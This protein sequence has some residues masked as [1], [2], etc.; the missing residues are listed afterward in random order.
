MNC[1]SLLCLSS[2]HHKPFLLGF[3]LNELF[4]LF[5]N[6]ISLDFLRKCGAQRWKRGNQKN[7]EVNQRYFWCKRFPDKHQKWRKKMELKGTPWNILS[8]K[9]SSNECCFLPNFMGSCTWKWPRKD[10]WWSRLNSIH[11]VPWWLSQSRILSCHCWGS[12]YCC[13]TVRSLAWEPLHAKGGPK[14]NKTKTKTKQKTQFIGSHGVSLF[15]SYIARRF[16]ARTYSSP[17]LS[18][19]QFLIF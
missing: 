5:L 19:P 9:T 17:V 12:G 16:P 4:P 10:S 1:F 15:A 8:L 11:R 6:L 14:K 3:L 2:Y 13:G 7:R 18:E